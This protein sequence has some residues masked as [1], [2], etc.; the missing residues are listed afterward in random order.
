MFCSGEYTERCIR[1]VPEKA[2]RD[3]QVFGEVI[4]FEAWIEAA[5][6]LLYLRNREAAETFTPYP[7]QRSI[8]PRQGNVRKCLEAA[9]MKHDRGYRR[10]LHAL[11]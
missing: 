10:L 7:L 3:A 2:S 11:R 4:F 5:V 9:P 8:V 6:T 1:T